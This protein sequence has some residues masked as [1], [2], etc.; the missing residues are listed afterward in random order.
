SLSVPGVATRLEPFERN[1]AKFD[2]TLTLAEATDG[3]GAPAGLIGVLEYSADLLEHA[4]AEA[5]VSRFELL[6]R[7]AVAAPERAV[8][9]LDILLAE[10]RRMLLADFNPPARFVARTTVPELVEGQA[11]RAGGDAAVIFRDR[12]ISYAELNAS[13]NLLANR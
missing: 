8:Q 12:T 6:L 4:S 2:L 1:V 3:H 11:R 9:G 10:E 5:L 13:A 7:Q